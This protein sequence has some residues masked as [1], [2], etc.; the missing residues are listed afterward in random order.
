MAEQEPFYWG[1]LDS[2]GVG[3]ATVNLPT[4]GSPPDPLGILSATP[5][6]LGN[7]TTGTGDDVNV[8]KQL[9]PKNGGD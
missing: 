1:P 4:A 8:W 3:H 6:T 5:P 9:S 2:P 7:K